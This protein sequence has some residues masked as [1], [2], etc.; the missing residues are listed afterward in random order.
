MRVGI[1]RATPSRAS[2]ARGSIS[3]NRMPDA[4]TEREELI[5]VGRVTRA[6]GIHGEVAVLPLSQVESRFE[7]GSRLVVEG[8]ERRVTVRSSRP[9]RQRLLITFEEVG[10]RTEAETLHGRY[11]L[12][13]TS[14]VPAPPE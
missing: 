7:P 6:H 13:P 2:G 1:D 10:D 14:D 4:R 12:V 5:A 9:H 11:L 8:L 3:M